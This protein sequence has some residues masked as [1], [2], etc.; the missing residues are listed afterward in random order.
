[1]NQC[2]CNAACASFIVFPRHHWHSCWLMPGAIDGRTWPG[3]VTRQICSGLEN[4]QFE[5]Q[6]N[7]ILIQNNLQ[8][9][10]LSIYL[11]I[12]IYIL[13]YSNYV[14]SSRTSTSTNLCSDCMWLL[15]KWQGHF[16]L[17]KIT[18]GWGMKV[19]SSS[20]SS[21]LNTHK[22]K[23]SKSHNYLHWKN[24]PIINHHETSLNQ[25]VASPVAAPARM[26]SFIAPLASWIHVPSC[27]QRWSLWAHSGATKGE[28]GVKDMGVVQNSQGKT[29][30]IWW[31]TSIFH[32]TIGPFSDPK[33]V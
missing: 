24:M 27:L 23:V 11:S 33:W 10:Y 26:V 12:Y 28:L 6:C 15:H 13:W 22:W 1:M 18:L 3:Y 30:H 32:I 31:S 19:A 16:T 8:Y 25:V 5:S 20:V 21:H 4:G 7:M 14:Q 17:T 29:P 2:K 9:V